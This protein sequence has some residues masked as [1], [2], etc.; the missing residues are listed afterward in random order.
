MFSPTSTSARQ[1]QRQVTTRRSLAEAEEQL[2]KIIP[3]EALEDLRRVEFAP[4]VLLDKVMRN[5]RLMY[6]LGA[7]QF[8]GFVAT[9]I[10]ELGFE[11]CHLDTVVR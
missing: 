11:K 2:V 3:A 4:I 5:P 7:R 8:E 10:E 6:Q 9:L 1:R